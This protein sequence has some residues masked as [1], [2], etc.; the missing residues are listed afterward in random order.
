MFENV[1][2]ENI[3][4]LS[5]LGDKKTY[6]GIDKYHELARHKIE[7]N[8]VLF[9]SFVDE[10]VRVCVF[11]NHKE[12]FINKAD[13]YCLRPDQNQVLT[14]Y[15]AYALAS[16]NSYQL[17]KSQVQGVTRPRINLAML[18]S[19]KFLFPPIGEQ[20]EIIR[21]VE[22]LFGFADKVETQVKTALESVNHLTQSILAQA[23]SGELTK[24]WR[25]QNPDLIS[26]ENSAAALLERIKAEREKLK[27]TKKVQT[28][29]KKTVV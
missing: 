23:F 2:L 1:R 13:C 8:D 25:E 21:R 29:T 17:I 4:H 26:G 3:G 27:P 24:E 14:N 16:S 5:F 11:P 9:S 19:M 10:Q 18:K 12:I 28:R 20:E 7:R 6:I 15:L 22:E